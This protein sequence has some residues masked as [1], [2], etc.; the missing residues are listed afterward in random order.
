MSYTIF[1]VRV[2]WVKILLLIL[3]GHKNIC[4][5]SLKWV[6]LLDWLNVKPVLRVIECGQMIS[7][8]I[9]GFQYLKTCC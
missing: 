7:L 9:Y 8:K 3:L 1:E 4:E 5:M 6:S 2:F